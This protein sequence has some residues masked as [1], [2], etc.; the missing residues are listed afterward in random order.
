MTGG[1]LGSRSLLAEQLDPTPVR[2]RGQTLDVALLALSK[3]VGSIRTGGTRPSQLGGCASVG[4]A[5]R[6]GRRRGKEAGPGVHSRG[7]SR[8]TCHEAG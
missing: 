1:C 2:R 5:E 8:F 4:E 6:F 3:A 7:G